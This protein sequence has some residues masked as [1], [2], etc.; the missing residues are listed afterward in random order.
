MLQDVS[1]RNQLGQYDR[2]FYDSDQIKKML[3]IEVHDGITT[4]NALPIVQAINGYL[5]DSR[6]LVV[7]C[8]VIFMFLKGLYKNELPCSGCALLEAYFDVVDK[9]VIGGHM[10][11]MMRITKSL[12]AQRRLARRVKVVVKKNRISKSWE[13]LLWSFVDG[14]K[15]RMVYLKTGA[16]M[17]NLRYT[18]LDAYVRCI[19]G[20]IYHDIEKFVRNDGS[21]FDDD[22]KTAEKYEQHVIDVLRGLNENE[23]NRLIDVSVAEFER[24][25]TRMERLSRQKKEE[26]AK[27]FAE[28]KENAKEEVL[29]LCSRAEKFF[30]SKRNV[31]LRALGKKYSVVFAVATVRT[32]PYKAG[33]AQRGEKGRWKSAKIEN[34]RIFKNIEDATRAAEEFRKQGEG[35]FAEVAEIDLGKYGFC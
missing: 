2:K 17:E 30:V 20:D 19:S 25:M 21:V 26:D 14:L 33:Y 27:A 10:S 24:L 29:A 18:P 1:R 4:P 3:K 5:E 15:D 34:A 16:I 35:C 8:S 6:Y 12:A 28:R 9:R 11:N 23:A 13:G 31:S 32:N 7:Q 22:D